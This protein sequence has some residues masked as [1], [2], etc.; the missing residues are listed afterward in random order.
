MIDAYHIVTEQPGSFNDTSK[1]KNY[2]LHVSEHL[3]DPWRYIY[4]APNDSHFELCMS[5]S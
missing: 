1:V 4:E 2:I 3:D 5:L